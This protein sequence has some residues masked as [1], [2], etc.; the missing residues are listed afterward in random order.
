MGATPKMYA[1][2]L[3]NLE[4]LLNLNLKYPHFLKKKKKKW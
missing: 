4:F 2:G 1:L 3:R